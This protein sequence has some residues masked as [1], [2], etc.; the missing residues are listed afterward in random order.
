M[1]E[2][3]NCRKGISDMRKEL[4][5]AHQEEKRL[6]QQLK[7][8]DLL[9][10]RQKKEVQAVMNE[11]DIVNTQIVRRNDEMN[12]QYNKLQILTETLSRGEKQYAQRLEEIRMLKLEVKKLRMDKAALMK[13]TSN[14]ND[15]RGEVFN[16]ER[17][18]TKERIKV[19][20]LEEEMQNPLNIHRWRNLEVS[21][22]GLI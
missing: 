9:M 19:V 11:R 17:N 8:N 21:L 14:L 3:E 2:L 12:L 1:T 13:H 6:R 15:L 5:E 20:A 22:Q 16:L 4:E 7:D 18:L 10:I